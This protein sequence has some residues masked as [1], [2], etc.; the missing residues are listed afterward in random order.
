MLNRYFRTLAWLIG[1]PLFSMVSRRCNS[2]KRNLSDSYIRITLVDL[3]EDWL[4]F[5]LSFSPIYTAKAVMNWTINNVMD[6]VRESVSRAAPISVRELVIPVK[7]LTII[8]CQRKEIRIKNRNII[9]FLNRAFFARRTRIA[10]IINAISPP[11]AEAANSV[12]G[13]L[14]WMS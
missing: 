13:S 7:K 5:I 1:F 8:T 2:S 10:F 14:A 11:S 12:L 6:T 9:H 3:L 4:L